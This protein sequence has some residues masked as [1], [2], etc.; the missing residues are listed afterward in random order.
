MGMINMSIINKNKANDTIK[1][2]ASK[3]ISAPDIASIIITTMAYFL[4]LSSGD[5]NEGFAIALL[6][7]R[8]GVFP[9]IFAIK[10]LLSKSYKPMG[11]VFKDSWDIINQ[12][13]LDDEE[14]VTILRNY[15]ESRMERWLKYWIK[16]KTIVCKD[17]SWKSKWKHIKELLKEI[18]R[19]EINIYQLAWLILYYIYAILI[20]TNILEIPGPYDLVISLVFLAVIYYATG[21]L[22]GLGTILVHIFGLLSGAET[23]ESIKE[24]LIETEKDL[25]MGA[26]AYYFYTADKP[27]EV[28][29]TKTNEVIM[30]K[31]IGSRSELIAHAENLEQL[32]E[33]S[34][35]QPDEKAK[36]NGE[37]EKIKAILNGQ[38]KE[39]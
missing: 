15:L 20:V 34:K 37:I 29:E 17:E 31:Q 36:I 26:Q 3:K 8:L 27:N 21:D 38:K 6:V 14:K 23:E 5:I 25:K 19:G 22:I 2:I 18:Y 13:G 32:S 12:P 35:A 33:M 24:A 9:S 7:Y 1:L 30:V 10:S 39:E 28:I 16:F 11:Y 4:L